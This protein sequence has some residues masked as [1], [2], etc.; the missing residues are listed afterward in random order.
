MRTKRWLKAGLFAGLSVFSALGF[1]ACQEESGDFT[2][3]QKGYLEQVVVGTEF[4]PKEYVQ[5]A[6]DASSYTIVVSKIDGSD[7]EDV[8]KKTVWETHDAELG[9]YKLTY[10]IADGENKGTYVCEFDIVAPQLKVL[11]TL[12]DDD[13]FGVLNETLNFERWFRGIEFDITSYQN[14][15]EAEMVS[16]TI[17]DMPLPDMTQPPPTEGV[18]DTRQV[19]DLTGE[20][21]Y[22]FTSTEPHYFRFKITSLDGQ[23]YSVL[24]PLRVI[25]KGDQVDA[26]LESTDKN[27]DL[28]YGYTDIHG[29]LAITNDLGVTL[30]PGWTRASNM[31]QDVGYFAFDGE[32]GVGTYVK[33]DF[34]GDNMPK[35]LFFA[36]KM[37][38][39]L[40]DGERGLLI[41]NGTRRWLGGSS[42]YGGMTGF[43]DMGT[44]CVY[45]P[46][47]VKNSN[48]NASNALW[49]KTNTGISVNELV[50]DPERKYQ[51]IVGIKEA[52]DASQ[53]SGAEIPYA[54]VDMLVIDRDT[55]LP[56]YQEQMKVQS[57]DFVSDYFTGCIQL[58]GAMGIET[59]FDK[60]YPLYT[61]M[62]SAMEV[63]GGGPQFAEGA[64]TT[65]NMGEAIEVSDYV[66]DDVTE[67]VFGYVDAANK[68][69][70]LFQTDDNGK[71]TINVNAT[72][73]VQV[74]DDT[75]V[76]PTAGKYE[77]YFQ[78]PDKDMPS[79]LTITVNDPNLV[80]F[81]TYDFEDGVN[82]VITSFGTYANNGLDGSVQIV[83]NVIKEGNKALEGVSTSITNLMNVNFDPTFLY[84]TFEKYGSDYFTFDMYTDLPYLAFIREG[85][86]FFDNNNVDATGSFDPIFKSAGITYLLG[87]ANQI[88]F[89]EAAEKIEYDGQTL[90]RFTIVYTKAAWNRLS[91]NGTE[92]PEELKPTL[93]FDF[94]ED[95]DFSTKYVNSRS[96]EGFAHISKNMTKFYI[97]NIQ[98]GKYNANDIDFADGNATGNFHITRGNTYG[99]TSVV[100]YGEDYA[101]KHVTLENTQASTA[102]AFGIHLEYLHEVFNKQKDG[103]D[104]TALT[105]K[106]F[107][108]PT[109]VN[110][111]SFHF[112]A[113]GVNASNKYATAKGNAF[114]TTFDPVQ[115]CYNV[116]ITK[117]DYSRYFDA[118]GAW[119]EGTFSGLVSVSSLALGYSVSKDGGSAGYAT[120]LYFDD[121]KVLNTPLVKA[122][123]TVAD[124]APEYFCGDTV[125]LETL[126]GYVEV[127]VE[128]EHTVASKEL[129]AISIG[130][131]V[132]NLNG[133]TEYQ[134]ID[135]G[136]HQFAVL[137]KMTD[138][139]E[140]I[141]SATFDIQYRTKHTG[142][143]FVSAT[144]T[145]DYV[146]ETGALMT[147]VRING[148]SVAAENVTITETTISF[149]KAYLATFRGALEITFKDADGIPYAAYVGVYPETI[150]FENGIND[151]AFGGDSKTVA[152]GIVS[153]GNGVPGNG[154]KVLKI[155]TNSSSMYFALDKAYV[156]AVFADPSVTALEY[157]VYSGTEAK[158]FVS[159]SSNAKSLT[160]YYVTAR[161]DGLLVG[162]SV[163]VAAGYMT[164]RYDADK[165]CMVIGITRATWEWISGI[166]QTSNITDDPSSP[167][168]NEMNV[169]MFLMR[170]S[171]VNEQSVWENLSYIYIDDL[172]IVK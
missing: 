149:T 57:E 135:K 134:F 86:S 126:L 170:F 74:T 159:I 26:L 28:V 16:V 140:A 66:P 50:T 172:K 96:Q 2:G 131:K 9:K 47:K 72:G 33:V 60:V 19:I 167:N 46:N 142:N 130:G 49:A 132:V 6:S 141:V 41:S 107:V 97:D 160:P 11:Y 68:P 65:Q 76:I 61:N 156:D 133:L 116:V 118:N 129:T 89:G 64:P 113:S 119:K 117:E 164:W 171:T 23:S 18:E 67:Y 101:F 4:R 91:Q 29:E 100:K 27:G 70:D 35:V 148:A 81:M 82:S 12:E 55:N 90:Y 38:N 25:T 77:L 45:G 112:V 145:G 165:K 115:Q 109:K 85:G 15:Y 62:S 121:F 84:N 139:S 10:T 88:G 5:I 56:V 34:T 44:L 58:Y 128:S 1:V 78:V 125:S 98:T 3:F 43:A 93:V 51:L 153:T 110:G 147:D 14:E 48:F 161:V 163:S 122:S 123:A 94:S 108:D 166:Y 105:F 83:E 144:T 152:E 71:T 138:G 21:G 137:V 127:N 36:S 32:Y 59:T 99:G 63:F 13:M 87:E 42:I 157:S 124:N 79:T 20:T 151:F 106:V 158:H 104:V 146:I 169:Y 95:I 52:K 111:A 136:S 24:V 30:R 143:V 73:F 103:K 69:A 54:I 150:D 168:L 31:R 22:T 8:T 120:E 162:N 40:V 92:L 7:A 114:T 75:F 37:T 80:A 155:K 39:S 154:T 53:V 102:S 17:G